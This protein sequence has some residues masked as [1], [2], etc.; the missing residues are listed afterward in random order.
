MIIKI[1]H[2]HLGLCG[3]VC[4]AVYLIVWIFWGMSL[5]VVSLSI[6]ALLFF[7]LALYS[8]FKFKK[9]GQSLN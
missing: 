6:L 3:Y 2:W 1:K 7:A 8:L 5:V 4:L 9:R